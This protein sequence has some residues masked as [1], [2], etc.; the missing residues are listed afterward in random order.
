MCERSWAS[1]LAGASFFLSM[2][3]PNR[4]HVPAVDQIIDYRSSSE[5]I[6]S[7]R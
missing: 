4:F 7:G 6:F 2:Y 3:D 5:F 1:A